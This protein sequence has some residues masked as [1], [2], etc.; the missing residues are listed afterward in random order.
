M[1]AGWQLSSSNIN[2]RFLTHTLSITTLPWPADWTDIYGRE[3][4][5]M[6]E[7]GFG[8]SRFLVGLAQRNPDKNILGLEIS[9]PSLRKGERKVKRAGLM[10]VRFIQA[11]AQAAL[12]TLCA[13][14]SVNA[15]FIN[16]PDPWPKP[17]H[18]RRRLIDDR[19]LQLVA[20]RM[21]AGGMIEIATDHSEYAEWIYSCLDRS[22]H[23][24]SRLGS[25][26]VTRDD[27]RVR[28][29]YEEKAFAG[30]QT[31]FYFKWLRNRRPAPDDFL[32]P[33]EFPMPHMVIQIPLNL[34]EISQ[35]FR[36]TVYSTNTT[37]VRLIDLYQSIGQD[38][39]VVD[40]YISEEP[41][42]QRLLLAITWRETGDFLIHL[43][44]V[45]FPRPTP[46]VHYALQC[47]TSWVCSL[48]EEA[49]VIRQN[50]RKMGR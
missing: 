4:A 36:P 9:S 21:N 25:P 26:Y 37:S 6:V 43:H 1:R 8:D 15:L 46:G 5:L 40:T 12:W 38:S 45:G 27:D 24:N 14:D 32:I 31:C 33:Q 13:T 44:E 22:P 7:V 19:F 29:K 17:A 30:G 39:L 20:T 11:R 42:E 48:H 50:L 10:N 41:V 28:T 16:F 23:F 3:A 18:H 35:R 2:S 49:V 34:E 47:L